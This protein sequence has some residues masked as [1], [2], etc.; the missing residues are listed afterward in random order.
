MS[1]LSLL[2]LKFI[3]VNINFFQKTNKKNDPNFTTILYYESSTYMFGTWDCQWTKLLWSSR[4]PRRDQLQ[5]QEKMCTEP[6][7]HA[8][9]L[10][11]PGR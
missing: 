3:L 4:V 8:E 9:Q 10:L 5:R 1:V 2:I 11:E 7:A 6:R